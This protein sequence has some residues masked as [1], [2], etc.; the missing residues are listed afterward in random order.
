MYSLSYIKLLLTVF[1]YIPQVIANFRRR[2]TIG[3]SIWQQL[4]DFSGGFFSLLQL[5]IDSSLQADWSGLTGNPIKFGLSN[6]SMFF[7]LIF[8]FQHYVLFG[9]VEENTEQSEILVDPTHG[10]REERAE[11]AP[12]LPTAS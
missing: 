6:I 11:R 7:D 3:W 4:L 2:S 8:I 1:K 10:P 9:P 12:L 5:V